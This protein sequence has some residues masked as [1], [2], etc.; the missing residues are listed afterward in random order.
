MKAQLMLLII[1]LRPLNDILRW[2]ADHITQAICY[3]PKRRENLIA[4]PH[5]SQLFPSDFFILTEQNM[6]A[7]LS[8]NGQRHVGA[9]PIVSADPLG[10]YEDGIT[11]R[12]A[13]V[14][15]RL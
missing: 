9:G 7:G 13:D 10:R 8:P 2:V 6:A 12:A 11:I 3:F 15:R 1:Q 14:M 4:E 5:G